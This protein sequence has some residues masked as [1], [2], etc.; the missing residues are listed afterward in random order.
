MVSETP[1]KNRVKIFKAGISVFAGNI[2]VYMIIRELI[3]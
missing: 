3:F 2:K 1:L